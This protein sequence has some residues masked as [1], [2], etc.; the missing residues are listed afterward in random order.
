MITKP[1]VLVL[2]AGA[3]MP[4]DFPSASELKSTIVR[5]LLFE[6]DLT[7]A[8]ILNRLGFKQQII[9]K[10]GHGLMRSALP[11]VDIYLDYQQEFT[12]IGKT[13]I[14]LALIPHENENVPYLKTIE[15]KRNWYDYLWSL[16]FAPY[17]E[18]SGNNLSFINFNYDRSIEHFLYNCFHATF[19]TEGRSE[20]DINDKLKMI[21]VIHVYGRLCY[22][23]WQGKPSRQYQPGFD[24]DIIADARDQIKLISEAKKSSTEFREAQSL[25]SRAERVYF[26]GFGYH[27]ANLDRLAFDEIGDKPIIGTSYKLSKTKCNNIKAKWKINL[28]DPTH[29]ITAFLEEDVTLD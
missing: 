24:S 22:L 6:K 27:D 28:P 2:G 21:K 29:D 10:F 20:A 15:G 5:K 4:F 23:P 12:L 11:S 9:N 3:S 19:R 16:M 13:C 1:T 7:W 26:L 14:A 8:D 25:L 18:V 17:D